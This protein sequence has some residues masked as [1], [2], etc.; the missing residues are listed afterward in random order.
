MLFTTEKAYQTN[1]RTLVDH[2]TDPKIAIIPDGKS[3][4]ELW[5]I[6]SIVDGQV[7]EGDEV[8]FDITHGFRS[9]PFLALLAAAYLREIKRVSIKAVTYGAFE[10]GTGSE[11]P[12]FDLSAFIRIFDWMDA[13]RS[14]LV[15]VDAGPMQLLIRDIAR[16]ALQADEK[17]KKPISLMALARDLDEF[18]K[19]V[20][21]SRPEEAI[22]YAGSIVSDLSQVTDE[23]AKHTPP[24][25]PVIRRI[26]EVSLLATVNQERGTA[27][28]KEGL[29][30]Q[31]RLIQFQ[32]E[33]GLYTQALILAREW[34][35]SVLI[36]AAG[37]G[38]QWLEAYTRTGAEMAISGMELKLRGKNYT[39]S[40]YSD[41]FETHPLSGE[42]TRIWGRLSKLRNDIAHC[43]MS[44]NK[45]SLD[46]IKNNIEA[47]VM[48]L[49]RFF[50][51]AKSLGEGESNNTELVG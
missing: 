26:E 6:F 5:E 12:I 25:M 34:M 47:M 11:T 43:G 32:V 21:L 23:I 29:I 9:L 49:D 48:D 13:V 51:I 20:R 18:T 24:L 10:A 37:D 22:S 42:C 14:F 50:T 33:K 1:H 36:A 45:K 19:A 3:E 46:S 41:W 4:K 16:P 2:F 30:L 38:K 8:I 31:R 15:H 40:S 35:I 27:L 7:D 44:T 39:R 17:E 28:T